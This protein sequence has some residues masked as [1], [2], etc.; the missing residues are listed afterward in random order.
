MPTF[1]TPMTPQMPGSPGSNL[2]QRLARLEGMFKIGPDGSVTI[3]CNGK[4][5]IKA[6]TSVEIEGGATVVLKG[7][8]SVEVN[9]GG[10]LMLKSAG[11]ANLEGALVKLNKGSQPLARTGDLVINPMGAP[12]TVQG[13]NGTV[14]G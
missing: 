4:V 2:E 3:E 5:R 6:A 13:G 14:L 8:S 10:N 11:T 7:S 12:G 1:M 9:A